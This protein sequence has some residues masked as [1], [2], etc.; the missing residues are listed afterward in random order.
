MLHQEFAV[1]VG[2]SGSRFCSPFS[3]SQILEQG[4]V[5]NQ[6]GLADHIGLALG[7]NNIAL[8]CVKRQIAVFKLCTRKF[9]LRVLRVCLDQLQAALLRV[10]QL[11]GHLGLIWVRLELIPLLNLWRAPILGAGESDDQLILIVNAKVLNRG[12]LRLSGLGNGVSAGSHVVDS[13]SG[14]VSRIFV[15]DSGILCASVLKGQ[16]QTCQVHMFSACL[17]RQHTF[18]DLQIRLFRVIHVHHV[19]L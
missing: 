7:T 2:L 8:V 3:S 16:C 1:S 12:V 4:R 19:A 11:H 5:F 15:K 6:T 10:V 14:F 9:D 18:R 17:F 13:H